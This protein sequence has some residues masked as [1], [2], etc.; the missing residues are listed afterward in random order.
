MRRAPL[1]PTEAVAW[2]WQPKTAAEQRQHLARVPRLPSR[3]VAAGS[4]LPAG[5]RHDL[6]AAFGHD[7][8]AVRIHAEP[9]AQATATAL[10]ARAFTVGDHIV[11]GPGVDT[12]DRPEGRALLSHELTH[13]VQQ[14][15]VG[16]APEA[17]TIEPPTSEAEREADHAAGQVVAGLA[18]QRVAAHHAHPI[19]ARSL[20]G[21]LLGGGLGATVGAIGGALLGGLLGPAGAIVGGIVGGLAGLVG[22]AIVGDVATRSSRRLTSDERIYAHE[23]YHDSVDYDAITITKG[24]MAATG[25]ARTI[26]NTIN[27]AARHFKG[28]TMELSDEGELTLIHEMGHVWQYQNGGL[29]YIPSSLIPQ[30]IAGIRG[31]SRN[32]VYNWRESIRSKIPWEGWNAEQ[33]AQCISDYNAA[34]RRIKADVGTLED[35]ETVTLAE[36]YIERVRRR[37]GAPGSSRRSATQPPSAG[38]SRP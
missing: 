27:L 4:P 3:E 21:G 31:L 20:L 35:Y 36:P 18:V 8:G 33:Q 13:V 25:T 37:E 12:P 19:V 28:D 16:G 7:F 29:D 6:E 24:S 9:A 30:A 5:V 1:S 38:E 10:G 2:R 17:L 26:G 34:L 22:G 14:A 11:F 15:D 32:V 23:I